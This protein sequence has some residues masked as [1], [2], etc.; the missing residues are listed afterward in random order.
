MRHHEFVAFD[1]PLYVTGNR[2]V[3]SGLTWQG[4]RW[5]FTTSHAGNWHPLTWL[6]HMADVQFFGPGPAAPHVVNLLLHVLNASHLRQEHAAPEPAEQFVKTPEL[7][8]SAKSL[9][10]RKRLR[11]L[12]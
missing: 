6:S 12:D 2:Q 11:L 10:E 8:G 5:A 9:L 3:Q 4:I 7:E 1:D